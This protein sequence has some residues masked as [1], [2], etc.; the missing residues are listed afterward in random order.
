[1]LTLEIESSELI[2]EF[3]IYYTEGQRL[4]SYS[5]I[6]GKRKYIIRNNDRYLLTKN[7]RDKDLKLEG[8]VE[9]DF[10]IGQE[11][12][13]YLKEKLST[14]GKVEKLYI[15]CSFQRI[16]KNFLAGET[17]DNATIYL[18]L[19]VIFKGKTRI[20]PI[21]RVEKYAPINSIKVLEVYEKIVNEIVDSYAAIMNINIY[22][23]EKMRC[24]LVLMAGEGGILIHEGIGHNL[25]ADSYFSKDSLLNETIGKKL[26][27]SYINIIDSCKPCDCIDQMLSDDGVR[28]LDVKLVDKGSVQEIMSD[29]FTSLRFGIPNTGNGRVSSLESL[30]I[31]R[32]RN[33]YLERG[34][35]DP[36]LIIKDMKEGII[37]MELGGGSVDVYTGQFVFRVSTGVYVNAGE[38]LGLVPPCLFKGNV[39]RTLNEVSEIGNDLKFKI[40]KCM[41]EGQKLNVSFGCPTIKV[42][43]QEIYC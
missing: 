35:K 21:R 27:N 7:D 14:I 24:D 29:T 16:I 22:T 34:D 13:K 26:F 15:S 1:M 19:N 12:Y 6:E 9:R 33:T 41:K 42:V 32:M 25:E 43:G 31:P 2:Q 23:F 37:A 17:W 39:L 28:T 40:A 10:D 36:N 5:I 4:T 18:E 38:I 30:V 3:V 20:I 11:G 8:I